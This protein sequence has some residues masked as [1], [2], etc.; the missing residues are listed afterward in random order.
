MELRGFFF[1]F[2]LISFHSDW[3]N[4]THTAS[5]HTHTAS[6]HTRL[7]HTHTASTHIHARLLHT[8]GFYTHGIYTH[9]YTVF[10]P[11]LP[12][13]GE[14]F[15]CLGVCA[16]ICTNQMSPT[17]NK[18]SASGWP[19]DLNCHTSFSW[20]SSLLIYLAD[21]GLFGVHN[22]IS[23]FFKIGEENGTPLQSSCL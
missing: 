1:F 17:P 21:F 18:S 7:L 20:V 2:L 22:F 8:H 14:F 15:I 4:I 11:L 6:T 16:H 13:R 10:G 3:I 19:S 12:G 23:P 9:T 5:T